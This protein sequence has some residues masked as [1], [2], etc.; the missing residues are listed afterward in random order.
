MALPKNQSELD[1]QI[2]AAREE[3]KASVSVPDVNAAT[4]AAVTADRNRRKEIMALPEAEKRQKLAAHLADTDTSVE[5]AKGILSASAEE[6]ATAAPVVPP[7]ED[8]Q[9]Q[10][11]GGKS[12]FEQRMDQDGGSGTGAGGGAD[13]G[14]QGEDADAKAAS[15]ILS[16]QASFTGA[17]HRTFGQQ[18]HQTRQ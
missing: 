2:A 14:G 5:A 12:Q 11:Q 4:A 6:A 18:Q 16:D 17:R 13:K 15:A 10:Q 3:G 8:Q 7:Q 1:A 9:Q